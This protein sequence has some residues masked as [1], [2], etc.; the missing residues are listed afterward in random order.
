[1]MLDG[2]DL[3]IDAGLS[4]DAALTHYIAQRTAVMQIAADAQSDDGDATTDAVA[5]EVVGRRG[6]RTSA[7]AP[8]ESK[9]SI[10]C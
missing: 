3:N 7:I 9:G 4:D 5:I 10:W 2:M 8:V 6:R 1:M